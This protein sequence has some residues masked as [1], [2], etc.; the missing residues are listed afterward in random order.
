[1]TASGAV[2]PLP[3]PA[4][5]LAWAAGLFEGEGSVRINPRTRK[6]LGALL[7]DIANVDRDIPAFFAARW[8]GTITTYEAK[9][10]QREYYRWRCSSKQAA[11]FL[12]AIL[13]H[14]RTLRY[15]ERALLGLEYQ[16]QKNTNAA[17]NRTPE[18]A[19]QQR[20]YF[21]RMAKL[22]LRGHAA[23]VTRTSSSK[24]AK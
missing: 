3:L 10:R 15:R 5:E 2:V 13:P 21:D 12:D 17:V 8:G 4:T 14:L 1:V 16:A 24:A 20:E 23:A 7:T 9:E 6:N 11:A 19:E 22:N 18:Y